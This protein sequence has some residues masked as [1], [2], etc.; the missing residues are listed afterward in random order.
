MVCCCLMDL[1]HLNQ[2]S[3][4]KEITGWSWFSLSNIVSDE[5]MEI[6]LDSIF[7]LRFSYTKGDPMQLTIKT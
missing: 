5:T 6:L 1:D 3:R 4:T 7:I 2:L